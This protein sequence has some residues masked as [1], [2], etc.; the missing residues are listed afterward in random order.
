MRGQERHTSG[1]VA[2]GHEGTGL[3]VVGGVKGVSGEAQS[4]DKGKHGSGCG[5]HPTL[6]EPDRGPADPGDDQHG[7]S[8]YLRRADGRRVRGGVRIAAQLVAAVGVAQYDLVEDPAA[9]CVG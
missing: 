9:G 8:A 2:A 6:P 1:W 5:Q 3:R 7:G 4:D